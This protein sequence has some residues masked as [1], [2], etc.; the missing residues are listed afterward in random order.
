MIRGKRYVIYDSRKNALGHM[1]K[2][3]CQHLQFWSKVKVNFGTLSVKSCGHKTC[4]R[5]IQ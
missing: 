2:G 5:F 1:V 4:Y 3:Q